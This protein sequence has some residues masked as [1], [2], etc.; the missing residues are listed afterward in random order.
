MASEKSLSFSEAQDPHGKRRIIM[1]APLTEGLTA[2]ISTTI[3][4]GESPLQAIEF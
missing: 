4:L 3:T 1:L 2:Q